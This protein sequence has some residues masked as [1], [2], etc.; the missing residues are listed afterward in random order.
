MTV[1][2]VRLA[3]QRDEIRAERDKAL[4]VRGFLEEVFAGSD[5]GEARGETVTARE[6]LDKGAARVMAKL[7][8]QPETQAALALAIG[9]VYLSLGLNDRALPL[10]QQSL[11]QRALYGDTHLDVADS[12]PVLS[13]L[14][15]NRGAFARAEEAQRRALAIQR[16]MLGDQDSKVGDTLTTLSVT[17]TTLAKYP[18]AETAV[19]EALAIH[20]RAPGTGGRGLRPQQPRI[21]PPPVREVAEAQATYREALACAPSSAQRTRSS[22]DDQQPRGGAQGPGDL[23]GAEPSFG[24]RSR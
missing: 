20:R 18:E 24:R 3:H 9:K 12:L 8:D 13:V 5:P 7:K 14:D 6:I 17:L 2:A 1:Q 10:L 23:A 4:E 16:R 15:Q 19:R 21:G 22:P 11:A